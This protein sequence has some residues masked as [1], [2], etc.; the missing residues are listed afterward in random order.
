MSCRLYSRR[1]ISTVIA[2]AIGS[3]TSTMT[4]MRK[5]TIKIIITITTKVR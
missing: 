5:T 1:R 2:L 4:I 3:R